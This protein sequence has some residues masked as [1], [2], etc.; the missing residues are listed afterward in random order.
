[1]NVNWSRLTFLLSFVQKSE[2][3]QISSS[4]FGNYI[5]SSDAA[6][7]ASTIFDSFHSRIVSHI[8]LLLSSLCSLFHKPFAVTH[9]NRNN[10]YLLNVIITLRYVFDSFQPAKDQFT[11]TVV[12]KSDIRFPCRTLTSCAWD[13]H[14]FQWDIHLFISFPFSIRHLWLGLIEMLVAIGVSL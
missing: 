12:F 7:T 1:M 4:S 3:K 8:K 10:T 13:Y 6:M 5:M 2:R 9:S 11:Q 14:H